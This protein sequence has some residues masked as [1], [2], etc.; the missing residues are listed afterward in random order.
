MDLKM[1]SG[2]VVFCSFLVL[3]A[4]C[5]YGI[6]S[7]IVKIAVGNGLDISIILVGKFFY[8]LIIL[9]I[10]VSFVH[11]L[12]PKYDKTAKSTISTW[13]RGLILFITGTAM[14]LVTVCYFYS[15][16]YLPISVA[17]ILLFQFSWMGVVIEAIANGKMPSRNQLIA[18]AIIFAGTIFAGGTTGFGMEIDPFGVVIALI[19]AF[20]YATFVFLSGRIEPSMM[21]IDRSFLI[22][23]T[24]FIF[25]CAIITCIDNP[26]AIFAKI[27][28]NDSIIY[29]MALGLFGVAFPILLLAIGTPRISTGIATILNAVELPVEILAA[30]I[31]L[32]ETVSN[33]QWIGVLAIL[34]GIAFPYLMEWKIS[35]GLV[36]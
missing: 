23:L 15:V 5:C 11:F 30:T 33:I 34:V 2:S 29:G 4:A 17:V 16:S 26:V 25:V 36:E 32:T 14:C 3:L 27:F 24:G 18:V 31:I 8:G 28:A 1:L 21:S 6:L 22:A 7:T 12:F 35:S 9:S 20:F 10:L 13:K 19:A